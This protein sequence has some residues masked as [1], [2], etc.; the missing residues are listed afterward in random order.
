MFCYF[1]VFAIQLAAN[2]TAQYPLPD[3]MGVAQSIFKKL[4]HLVVEVP[5]SKRDMTFKPI[6][7]AVVILCETFPPFCSEAIVFL[8][9]LCKICFSTDGRLISTGLDSM[10]VKVNST[11]QQHLLNKAI[12]PTISNDPVYGMEDKLEYLNRLTL[13]EGACWTFHQIVKLVALPVSGK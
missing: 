11:G 2:V 1:Q 12:E 10:Q 7:I 13:T 3:A 6:L 9:N 8:L 5:S 4:N